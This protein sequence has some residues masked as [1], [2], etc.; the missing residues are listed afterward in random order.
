MADPPGPPSTPTITDYDGA[1]VSLSWDPPVNDGGARIQ[2]YQPEYCDMADGR[3]RA[4]NEYLVKD[5]HFTS[6]SC[7]KTYLIFCF[8]REK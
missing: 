5:T 2:G 7:F 3:W 4:G 8:K 1:N 6:K